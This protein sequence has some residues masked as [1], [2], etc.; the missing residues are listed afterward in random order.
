M[1]FKEYLTERRLFESEKLLQQEETKISAISKRCGFSEPP[2]FIKKF[3]EKFGISPSEY[4]KLYQKVI[5]K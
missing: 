3:K 4:R 5:P 1:S 2:F